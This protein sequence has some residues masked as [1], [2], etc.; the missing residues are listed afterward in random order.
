MPTG[1]GFCPSILGNLLKTT[2]NTLKIPMP[3]FLSLFWVK[4]RESKH[5]KTT[6]TMNTTKHSHGPSPT[7]SIDWLLLYKYDQI[8]AHCC[9]AT[10]MKPS[11]SLSGIWCVNTVS[12]PSA[13]ITQLQLFQVPFANAAATSFAEEV[14]PTSVYNLSNAR[15]LSSSWHF[16]RLLQP[17]NHGYIMDTKCYPEPEIPPGVASGTSTPKSADT[18]TLQAS[19]RCDWTPNT[20]IA[21]SKPML[22]A[23]QHRNI[24][25]KTLRGNLHY[26]NDDISDITRYNEA[27]WSTPTILNM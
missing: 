17:K 15:T 2:G 25:N 6:D 5:T 13:K 22:E 14:S 18:A 23:N 16:W 1:P 19:R 27:L 24:Q 7:R 21:K 9:S 11:H 3:S 8:C 26:I 4:Q 20:F 12:H 10:Q